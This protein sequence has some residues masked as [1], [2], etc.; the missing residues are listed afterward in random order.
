MSSSRSDRAQ[1]FLERLG[2]TPELENK[3]FRARRAYVIG[4]GPSIGKYDL[5]R[6]DDGP[7]FG[8]NHAA[9][10]GVDHDLLFLADDRRLVPA[11]Q[12]GTVPIVTI[13]ACLDGHEDF[14]SGLDYFAD[15]KAVHYAQKIPAILD[16]GAYPEGLPVAYWT[17]SVVTDLVLPFAV[18]CGIDE[19]VCLGL[20]GTDG[21]FPIT[22]AWGIDSLTRQ[23]QAAS[24]SV[25][26]EVLPTTE[27]VAHL[28]E[29]AAALAA[30][31]GTQIVNATPGGTTEALGRIDPRTIL[32][33][34]SWLGEVDAASV[35]N[36]ALA[37][38]TSVFTLE[39][40]EANTLTLRHSHT[41][42]DRGSHAHLDGVPFVPEVGFIGTRHVSLRSVDEPLYLTTRAG[43]DRYQLRMPTQSFNTSLSSFPLGLSSAE[44]TRIAEL[45]AV[46]AELADHRTELG[47]RLADLYLGSESSAGHV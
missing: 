15:I 37:I 17:G 39:D 3:L 13:D 20:D 27:V 19:L 1:R 29:K 21:S 33:V 32:P 22:H 40:G 45:I 43:F 4:M 36:S 46:L 11:L 6:C 30:A 41:V 47:D 18:E 14:F 26:P 7:V 10:M 9:A 16:I 35:Q 28:Q 31:A 44:A 12:V 25:E 8:V 42:S 38:G 34:G 24:A 2:L 5:D 23:L